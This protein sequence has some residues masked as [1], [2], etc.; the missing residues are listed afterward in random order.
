VFS[1]RN[2]PVKLKL[3]FVVL[4]TT[5][6]ALL[7]ACTAFV[8]YELGT[9]RQSMAAKMT[10]L[11]DVVAISSEV[12]LSFKSPDDAEETLRAV[13]VDAA[14]LS[15]GLYTSKGELFA[16]YTRDQGH[17][18]LPVHPGKDGPQFEGDR[19][20]LFRPV[21]HDE[22]RIGTICIEA[23]LA[24]VNAR[25]RSYAVISGL[26]LAGAFLLAS[27]LAASLQ[28]LVSAPILNLAKTAKLV[29][30][31]KD[32]SVRASKQTEDE[33]GQLAG[34]FNQMLAG[35]QERD[36]T[37]VETNETLREQITARIE[38]EQQLK[39]LNEE[40][41]KRVAER[42]GDLRRSNEELEQ[43][44][45]VASHDL[46]EPLRM[47]VSYL[48]L[49]ERR[50]TDKFDADGLQFIGFAVDGGKRMQGLIHDLLTYSR[51]G[52]RA[53]P[54]ESTDCSQILNAV[55][56]NLK[57]IIEETG[58]AI[59]CG[60][61]PTVLADPTQLT[62]LFQNLINNA[63]KFRGQEPPSIQVS[64]ERN[65]TEWIFAVRDNGIGIDPQYF[66]RI[67]II[68]QRLHTRAQY[69]GT[70]IGLAVCKK[71]VQRHGGRIWV[72]SES[73]K[74][75]TFHFTIPDTLHSRG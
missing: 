50:Y 16:S 64:A 52:S 5:A 1:I 63:I 9:F 31:N 47:V 7:L 33:L 22:K 62:Q 48:Q 35:I 20:L 71:I 2:V 34:A 15:A 29:S 38:A 23:S 42:T 73:Q 51:V 30:E 75:S 54:F 18:G 74:G 49:L 10:A 8:A 14:I 45:Y 69:P 21:N 67:F 26:V 43:F 41:E 17:H 36:T 72:E 61:M 60:P 13:N 59:T 4:G 55:T 39:T 3:A 19:L 44:A 68:F 6:A 56:S 57:V 37:L 27:A 65:G 53:K 12:P 25:L 66:E 40:L 24:E 32:Y 70:G 28:R 46:Q 58:A 11:A